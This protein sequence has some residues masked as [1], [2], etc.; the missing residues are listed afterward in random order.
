[1]RSNFFFAGVT[2]G[3]DVLVF[4]LMAMAGRWLGADDFGTFSFA[5]AL[6]AVGMSLMGFGLDPLVVRELSRD[7]TQGSRYLFVMLWWKLPV[8]CI[9]A[10]ILSL[11]GH[12]IL[13]M[14]PM[15]LAVL[16]C[17]SGA[18][19]LRLLAIGLR[20]TLRPLGRYDLEAYCTATEQALLLLLGGT[21]LVL[22]YGLVGLALAFLVARAIGLAVSVAVVTRRIPLRWM[23]DIQL[24]LNLQRMAIPI[25]LSVFLSNTYAQSDTFLI[26]AF[27]DY[28]Q[29]GLYNVALKIYMGMLILPSVISSVL[30][31]RLSQTFQQSKSAHNRLVLVGVGIS[32]L[33]AV[34]I[35]IAGIVFAEPMI[36][37]VFGDGYAPSATA[38]KILFASFVVGMQVAFIQIFLIAV[39]RQSVLLVTSSSALVLRFGLGFFLI[40]TW[41][42]EGAAIAMALSQVFIFVGGWIY[43][44]RSHFQVRSL[45]EFKL[46][47]S[48]AFAARIPA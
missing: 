15:H 38:M 36:V 25:G 44:I 40:Q 12:Y 22:G 35:S 23:P 18:M 5:Q 32:I 21:A 33:V 46:R 14:P 42:I 19:L 11:V 30:L 37:L 45:N 3:S 13:H 34:P 27:S 2:N 43:L 24:F 29:V 1:M 47:A 16:A 4:V 48:E 20:V 39:R 10:I 26:K 17:I 9:C 41:G 8:G 6:A 7:T 28:E 31:P